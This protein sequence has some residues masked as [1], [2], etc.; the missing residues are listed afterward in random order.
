MNCC[1]V[2]PRKKAKKRK[3]DKCDG[4]DNLAAHL[5]LLQEKGQVVDGVQVY[6]F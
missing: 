6:R 1:K 4:V 3:R 5:N 2:T